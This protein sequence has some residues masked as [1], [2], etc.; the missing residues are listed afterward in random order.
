MTKRIYRCLDCVGCPL[1]EA[2]LSKKNQHGRTIMRDEY[3]EVRART[4]SRMATEAG[5]KTVQPAAAHR[6]DDLRSP[7][8]VMDCG[9]FSLRGLGESEDGMALGLYGLQPWQTG[10]RGGR[11][12]ALT[13]QLATAE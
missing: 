2:C 4:A 8:R 5:R 13:T 1:A 12:C 3:E 10:V 6:R 11:D 7:E 9:S